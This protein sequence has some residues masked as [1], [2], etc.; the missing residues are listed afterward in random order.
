MYL[1]PLTG[2]RP[3]CWNIQYGGNISN[4]P[5]RGATLM[6]RSQ[7]SRFTTLFDVVEIPEEHHVPAADRVDRIEMRLEAF[8]AARADSASGSG[9]P[10]VAASAPECRAERR[11]CSAPATRS[12]CARKNPRNASSASRPM[13][14]SVHALLSRPGAHAARHCGSAARSVCSKP[15]TSRRAEVRRSGH[16]R[17]RGCSPPGMHRSTSSA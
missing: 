10:C 8:L 15:A 11:G 9:G 13:S 1:S 4:R 7:N 5:V 6:P 14:S 2:G 16:R 3:A 12:I 17:R